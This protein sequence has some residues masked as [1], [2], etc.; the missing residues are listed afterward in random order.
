MLLFRSEE[1]V[2]AW[3]AARRLPVRPLVSLDQLWHLAQTWYANRLTVESRRPKA[4]EMPGI[5][6]AV[7]LVGEFWDPAGRF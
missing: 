3:C 4:D 5:F 2:G 1:N 7:G 6:A